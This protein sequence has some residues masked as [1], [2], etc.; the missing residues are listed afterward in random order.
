[1]RRECTGIKRNVAHEARF[2]TSSD[3]IT[4]HYSLFVKT[5]DI[6]IRQSSSHTPSIELFRTELLQVQVM[7]YSIPA[8]VSVV[9]FTVW[10]CNGL[11][12][13]SVKSYGQKYEL[14]MC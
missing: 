12:I 10:C 4:V 1:M 2:V 9:V 6:H 3:I 5:L 7:N 14:G 11:W 13:M 8:L